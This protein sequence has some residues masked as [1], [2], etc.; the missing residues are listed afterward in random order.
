[1]N[2]NKFALEVHQNAV[3]HGFWDGE[4]PLEET[5]AL[6]HS[7]WS[8]ALEEYRAGRPMHY[9][10][11]GAFCGG[12]YDRPVMM[13][14]VCET[15]YCRDSKKPEGVAVELIDGCIRIFDYIGKQSAS[16]STVNTLQELVATAPADTYQ[17]SLARLV[18]NMHLKTSQ[19][20]M[21][22]LH[23]D[24]D[25]ELWQ[26]GIAILFEAVAVPCAWIEK[27]G[28]NPE[29]LMLE[30]HEYNKTRPY[31]HGKKC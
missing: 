1:M 11:T 21:L 20:Y 10:F 2:L 22:L 19:A 30:K 31:K 24:D 3:D 16:L 14:D 15:A 23:A 8:E 27:Q 29:K 7:E 5:I 18:A 12:C 13:Q 9:Y 4:R 17:I 26:R 6:I 28:F 25:Y